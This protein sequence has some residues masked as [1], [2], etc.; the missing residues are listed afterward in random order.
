MSRGRRDLG[1]ATAELAVSLPALVLLLVVGLAGVSAV[2]TQLEC[3][4]AARELARTAA[5]GGPAPAAP[6]GASVTV[7]RDGD[8]VR[9]TVRVHRTPLGTGLP[10]F[11]IAASATAAIEPDQP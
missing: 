7:V 6:A 3:V 4:D 2:R 8:V 1:S 10:G 9:A 5:Q 11:D